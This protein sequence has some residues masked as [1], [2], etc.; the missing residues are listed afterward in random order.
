MT[1]GAV[2]AWEYGTHGWASATLRAGPA[3]LT[4][5]PLSACSPTESSQLAQRPLFTLA[6][7]LQP[8]RFAAELGRLASIPYRAPASAQ[9]AP[10]GFSPQC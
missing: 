5:V 6:A 10:P 1:H 3:L 9:A 8:C 4:L 2:I 7:R